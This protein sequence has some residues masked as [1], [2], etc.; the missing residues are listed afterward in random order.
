MAIPT[1]LKIDGVNFQQIR[2]NF[3]NYLKNQTQFKDYNFDA[4]GIS[5]LIDILSYNTYYNSFY[6]NMIATESNLNTAQRRNSIVNLAATLNYVPR[7]T[8]AS[9]IEGTLK[10]TVTGSLSQITLPQYTRFDAVKEGTTYS[11]L[12]QE[13]LTFTPSDDDDDNYTLR[14]IKLVQGRH[15]QERY[16]VNLE[17][18]SQKFLINNEK[19]DTSTLLVR[20]QISS[21][22][23]T[24]TVFQNPLNTI[25]N[26]N[27][28]THAYFLKEV[29]N[30]KY[31][32]TF[33][34]GIIGIALVTDNIV[35]L[36]YIVTE[37][38]EGNQI[39]Q[40]TLSSTV[41]NVEDASFTAIDPS[42]G[43]DDRESTE[44]IKFAAPKFYTAQ[45]RAVTVEDYRAI[46]LN[47]PNIDSVAVW[48]GEDN[49]P[50]SYGKVFIAIKPVTGEQLTNTEKNNIIQTTLKN[51]KVLTVQNEIVDTEYIF[52]QIVVN[53]KYDPEQT[54]STQESVKSKILDTVKNYNDADINEFSKYFR[55]SKLSRLIDTCERSILNSELILL[56][57]KEIS[58]QLNA[59]AKYTINFSNPINP[60]TLGRPISHP[61]GV[62][63]QIKSN[64]FSY[65][66]FDQCFLDD[67][68]GIIRIYQ[69]SGNQNLGIVQNLGTIDYTTGKIVLTDFQPTV[70]KNG[71]VT[72]KI[73]AK[74]SDKDI[75]PL[76]GQIIS[77]RDEDIT[78]NLINDKNI[79]L[80]KR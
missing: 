74:P 14:N 6:V 22:D 78:V 62:G 4:S 20:V 48:G 77:I 13:P 76:R 69:E 61:Y 28:T 5:T 64:E 68:N 70:F 58:V 35:I 39:R 12:T 30:G 38:A 53:A 71:G 63:S 50:P 19:V 27:E 80:V 34:D 65:G 40:I 37:G 9:K 52:I 73:F 46:L 55:Y 3:K 17:D 32:V 8:T 7:S 59:A 29:E 1:N 11:F 18:G 67:N 49:D 44:R 79:S 24:L 33:G 15:V 2:N 26:V 42:S 25:I 41:E 56:M 51:K 66:G 47:A 75:L 36:D 31:E 10:L 60:A 45:N 54:I 72:L 21:T 43:G 16:T 23:G 57:Y